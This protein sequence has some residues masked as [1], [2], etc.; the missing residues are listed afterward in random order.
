MAIQLFDIFLFVH[1][2]GRTYIWRTSSSLYK[3]LTATY[4]L[5]RDRFGRF[6]YRRVTVETQD[7]VF[8]LMATWTRSAR[9]K[10]FTP[11][12]S[13]FVEAMVTYGLK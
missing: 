7:V 11:T 1:T 12:K 3:V 6:R 8:K 13:S 10:R 2:S 9:S 4:G 5:K